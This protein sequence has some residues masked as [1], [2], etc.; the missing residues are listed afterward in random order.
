MAPVSASTCTTM[1]TSTS[2][3]EQI[4]GTILVVGAACTF[5]LVA[6]VVKTDQ[7]PLLVATQ[8]RFLVCWV[9][10][11][12]FMLKYRSARNL[13]WFGPYELRKW[14]LLKCALSFAF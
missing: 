11:I 13:H 1:A 14:L 9:V 12:A 4:E 7:L 2:T 3:S 10:A 8:C 6:L 5:A